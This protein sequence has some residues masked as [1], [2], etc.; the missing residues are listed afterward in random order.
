MKSGA[1]CSRLGMGYA[2]FPVVAAIVLFVAGCLVAGCKDENNI[3]VDRTPPRPPQGV[4]T[5]TGDTR[6]DIYWL[7]NCDSDLEGY[8]VY[9][10]DQPTGLYKYMA[11]TSS[12]HY[13]DTDVDNGVTY[14]YAVSAFDRAGN[15]SDLSYEIVSDTPRPEGSNLVL[16]DFNGPNAIYSGYVF[17]TGT[18]Q[19][20]S[21]SITPA[22]D[23]YYGYVGGQSV[24]FTWNPNPVWPLTDIQDAGYRPLV[25]LDEAPSAGWAEDGTAILT[26]GHSYFVWTRDNNYAKFYVKQLEA[27]YV[28]IDWAYQTAQGNPELV[29]QKLARRSGDNTEPSAT[30]ASV[31]SG[32]VRR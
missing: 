7:A 16:Y 12:T 22:T 21:L 14:Y 2:A 27:G 9:W 15:E 31:Q 5:V 8:R 18:R 28:V 23:I 20:Y 1:S 6:V 4:F 30:V 32:G 25:E 17:S 19:L 29:R 11:T 24:M 3:Y 10:N 26:L 13:I